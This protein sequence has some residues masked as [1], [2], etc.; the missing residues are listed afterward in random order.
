MRTEKK[1]VQD[2]ENSSNF[3]DSVIDIFAGKKSYEAKVQG[4]IKKASL[5]VINFFLI[6]IFFLP[7]ISFSV[8][9]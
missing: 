9:P 3:C 5:V 4:V 1:I 2:L 8:Y 6:Y 7:S